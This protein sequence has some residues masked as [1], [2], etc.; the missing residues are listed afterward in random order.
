MRRREL[1]LGLGSFVGIAAAAQAQQGC[2]RTVGLLAPTRVFATLDLE[3]DF[4]VFGW[5]PDRDYRL[6]F[7]TSDSSNERCRRSPRNWRRRRST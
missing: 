5:V 3:H 6:L 2:C 4:A 7:R 1:I